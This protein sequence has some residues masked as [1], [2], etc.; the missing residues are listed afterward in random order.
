[1]KQVTGSNPFATPERVS[2]QQSLDGHSFSR[3]VLAEIPEGSEVRVV[4]LILPGT[5]LVPERLLSEESARDLLA[6]NGTPAAADEDIVV[7]RRAREG[8]SISATANCPEQKMASR[9]DT[10]DTGK[11][12]PEFPDPQD[13]VVALVAVEKHLLQEIRTRFPE[14]RFSTPLLETPP[15]ARNCLWIRQHGELLYIK[16]YDTKARLRMAE[17]IPAASEAEVGY[18]LAAIGQIF[19]LK[20][21]ELLLSGDNVKEL[22]KWIGKQFKKVI[23][24]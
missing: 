15:N 4:E 6:A 20:E 7:C 1:M 10:D 3:P 13:K 18:L 14:A 22:R 8:H 2:I 21:Y 12:T 11:N 5:M 24:E 9:K 16:V 23:C 17:V 19:R